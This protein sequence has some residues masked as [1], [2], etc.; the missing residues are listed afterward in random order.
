MD[1]IEGARLDEWATAQPRPLRERLELF[2]RIADAVVHAHR[3]GVI[4]RDLKPSN[5]LVD[6]KALP[7]ELDF[8]SAKLTRPEADGGWLERRVTLTGEFMGTLAYASPEQVSGDPGAVDTRTDVYS[9]GVMLYELVT[10]RLPYDVEGPV[11]SAIANITGARPTPP[12]SVTPEVDGELATILET[13]LEKEPAA[14]Y[15]SVEALTRDVARYLANE[16][17]EA[18]GRSTWYVLRKAVE[19]H[20]LAVGVGAIALLAATLGGALLLREHLRAERQR[21]NA[22]LVREV[23]RDILDA[24]SPQRMGADVKLLAIFEDLARSIETSLAGAPDTQA[25]VQLTIGDTYRKLLMWQEA[26]PHLRAA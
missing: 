2:Q 4:H 23:F 15:A 1:L 7:H 10:G 12:A 20:R 5:V 17:I 21:A 24:A 25:A 3:R 19:R 6:A 8:G 9:L 16:P 18:R 13:A 22:V 11:S 26:E 14:R